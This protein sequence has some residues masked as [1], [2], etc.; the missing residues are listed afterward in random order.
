MG[1]GER[2]LP[3]RETGPCVHQQQCQVLVPAVPSQSLP[4]IPAPTHR[5]DLSPGDVGRDVAHE[6]RARLM[7]GSGFA[8]QPRGVLR[9]LPLFF[10]GL[11]L[12]LECFIYAASS[13]SQRK[14]IVE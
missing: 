11:L 9:L 5:N 2:D 3:I 13:G 12:F 1:P 8:F 10:L 14:L 6:E 7:Q 4:V